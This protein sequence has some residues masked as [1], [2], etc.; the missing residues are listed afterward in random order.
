MRY[1][2]RILKFIKK[3]TKKLQRFNSYVEHIPKKKPEIFV[4]L[5]SIVSHF[6]LCYFHEPWL[7]E[8][9][10]WQIA[11]CA[12]PWQIL[13]EV[14][15]YEGHPPL[16]HLVLL[17]FAKSGCP[18]ELS[19]DIVSGFFVGLTVF[20]LMKYAPL[21]RLIKLWLPFTYFYFYQ[22]N[23][24]SRPY[25]MMLLAFV[26]LGMYYPDRN[27]KPGRYVLSLLFLCLTSAFGIVLAGGIAL[28]W[29]CEIW[30]E[31]FTFADRRIL[32]L[33][34]LLLAAVCL[35]FMILP[36]NNTMG[37]QSTSDSAPNSLAVRLLYMFF[38][39]P[40][41]VSFITVLN[42]TNKLDYV[43]YYPSVFVTACIAGLMIW[44]FLWHFGKKRRNLPL[45]LVPY[46][47]YALFGAAVYAMNYH[48]GIGLLMIVFWLWTCYTREESGQAEL[49][50]SLGEKERELLVCFRT[51]LIAVVMVVSVSWSAAAA[52]HEIQ[53]RYELGSDIAGFIKAHGMER[54]RIMSRW[55]TVYDEEDNIIFRDVNVCNYADAIAPYFAHNILYNFRLGSDTENYSPHWIE[56]EEKTK[57]IMAQ[58]KAGGYPDI[59]IDEVDLEQLYSPEE[60]D[61]RDYALVYREYADMIWKEKR[62]Y[63]YVQIFVRRD[64]LD[65]LGVQELEE[66][67]ILY[68]HWA[69]GQ[70]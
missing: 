29:L 41:E 4:W 44:A 51:L 47:M 39:L 64:L 13:F 59:L 34:G 30:R 23:V 3:I 67:P 48:M 21:P 43:N 8:A 70:Q 31:R 15:H 14:P 25:C 1:D 20:L 5:A 69:E 22:Y 2:G 35:L 12:S 45:L 11:R 9:I 38:A 36:R 26:L 19:L 58:W 53:D 62:D 52:I 49:Q 65:E 6:V 55:N 56:S 68:R 46:T 28:V 32:W 10:A 7:D 57:E 33:G 54:Y 40:A 63:S 37:I 24:L 60:L 61:Y 50:I 27:K 16:W 66:K 42:Q 17:P 18:Y